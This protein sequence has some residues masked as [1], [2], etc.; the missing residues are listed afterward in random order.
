M[1]KERPSEVSVCETFKNANDPSTMESMRTMKDRSREKST[2]GSP[3]LK[4][5]KRLTNKE[6]SREPSPERLLKPAKEQK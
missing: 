3:M 2:S 1:E 6:R 5:A 4:K